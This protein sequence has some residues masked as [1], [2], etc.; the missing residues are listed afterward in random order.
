MPSEANAKSRGI[1]RRFHHARR[2]AAPPIARRAPTRRKHE[3]SNIM[4]IKSSH[5]SPVE[6]VRQHEFVGSSTFAI[7]PIN[8]CF[9]H[10][11]PPNC[12]AHLHSLHLSENET[13]C[14]SIDASRAE[15]FSFCR[16][17][18]SCFAVLARVANRNNA[19]RKALQVDV[20]WTSAKFRR[21]SRS[22]LLHSRCR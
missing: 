5:A 10:Q 14:R 9:H 18:P 16:L 19:P 22:L 3:A 4:M 12:L 1:T 2:D 21:A 6:I 15:A 7:C 13:T 8:C 17:P 20:G 11:L